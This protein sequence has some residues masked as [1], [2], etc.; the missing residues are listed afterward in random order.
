[1]V[2]RVFFS[3]HFTRDNWRANQVRNCWVTKPNSASAGYIDK[4]EFEKL[5]KS[6]KA[7]IQNWID[8]QLKGTSVTAVLIGAETYSREWV[9]YEIKQSYSKSKR[10]GLLGIYIHKLKNSEGKTDT[11]G[12]N[13]FDKWFITQ[14][15][16]KV[17][18]SE[19]YST[20]DWVS[21]NGYE[22][23]GKWVEKAATDAGR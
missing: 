8:E 11:K 2:R 4:A 3:F 17:Y 20:Y 12:L 7:A 13:P 15:G 21:D 6:G 23:F 1:M 10:N 18:F 5:K 19:L 14:N 9:N 16:Q 22:N